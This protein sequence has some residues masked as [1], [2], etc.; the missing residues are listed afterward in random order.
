MILAAT[1]IIVL[2]SQKTNQITHFSSGEASSRTSFLEENREEPEILL[3]ISTTI[4][5]ATP[6][7]VMSNF[8]Q[9][10]KLVT[11]H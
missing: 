4:A 6:K 11:A 10:M 8:Q 2:V 5:A 1:G 3:K 7:M 9:T